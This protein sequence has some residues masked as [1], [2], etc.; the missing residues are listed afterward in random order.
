MFNS[1]GIINIASSC[2]AGVDTRLKFTIE[3]S[4]GKNGFQQ[5]SLLQTSHIN[6]F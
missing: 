6:R 3:P 5:V 1:S 4:L 2:H